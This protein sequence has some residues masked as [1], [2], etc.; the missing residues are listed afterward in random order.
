M[1]Y[2]CL[3][4]IRWNPVTGISIHEALY[5]AGPVP[6]PE[7]YWGYITL[8]TTSGIQLL[9]FPSTHYHGKSVLMDGVPFLGRTSDAGLVV[10]HI[11]M[12]QGYNPLAILA[13]LFGSSNSIWGS[14]SVT[15]GCWNPI[16]KSTKC[17][18]AC[19]PL[20]TSGISLSFA[21][22]ADYSFFSDVAW[23]WGSV[24]VNFSVGD[25]VACLID[26]AIQWA[27]EGVG[28]LFG[29]YVL[30]PLKKFI[31]GKFTKAAL[32][33]VA[34]EA[35]EDFAK[36]GIEEVAE[37]AVQKGAKEA[38]EESAESV[39]SKVGTEEMSEFAKGLDALR[40]GAD[41]E[42]AAVLDDAAGEADQFSKGLSDL[43]DAADNEMAAVVDD[44]AAEA[45]QFSKGLSDLADEADDEL[46]A[47][48]D[49]AAAEA[50]QF[51]KG[52]SD[53][54]DEADD[55][56]K[57]VDDLIEDEGE[58]FAKDLDSFAKEA[59]EGLDAVVDDVA[60][61]EEQAA[62]EAT[63]AKQAAKDALD[64]MT[65]A[66]VA[67]KWADDAWRSTKKALG[68][69]Y[70][71]KTVEEAAALAASKESVF[72]GIKYALLKQAG[73]VAWKLVSKSVKFAVLSKYSGDRDAASSYFLPSVFGK[74]DGR[75]SLV[76]EV[77]ASANSSST[78][79]D[80]TD[81]DTSS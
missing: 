18:I 38:M 36:K 12:V 41:D 55:L 30:G 20:G 72:Q 3:P 27:I 37:D 43:A 58:A 42:L 15:I 7:E 17:D 5:M 52:L 73:T 8:D 53:L 39:A 48:V 32:T 6:V 13:T 68:K 69:A 26:I 80:W 67:Q 10:P 71:W 63:K 51:S 79:F 33:E 70:K 78:R 31:G 50:D 60:R 2:K 59:D 16:F 62:K 35:I 77:D 65:D 76:N 46:A 34:D 23:V 1:A 9:S 21:C 25:L 81:G 44:A 56:D 24:L 74:W 29:E 45:D 57:V 4:I 19:S 40:A 64:E 47:V 66:E 54:A 22:N 11:D 14:S 28:K 49:D 61:E 75:G